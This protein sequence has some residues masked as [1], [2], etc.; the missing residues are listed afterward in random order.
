[1]T[2]GAIPRMRPPAGSAMVGALAMSAPATT[3]P[4][5]RGRRI[6]GRRL[7]LYILAL[8]V[9]IV[10]PTIVLPTLVWRRPAP[11]LD[12]LGALPAFAL[13]AHTGEPFTDAEMRGHVSV[14]DFIFTRCDAI[15]PVLS[16]KMQGLQKATAKVGDRIKLVSFSVDP[17]HDTPAVLAAYAE[18]FQADPTRWAF[19]TGDST[20]VRRTIE[21]GLMV[22][23][24]KLGTTPSGA[25]NI[26]HSGHMVLVDR[27]GHVR[28]LYDSNDPQRLQDLQHHARWLSRQP[29]RQPPSP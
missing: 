17:E 12:D 4:V 6:G 5:P 16:M 25:P 19:V 13:T 29:S 10:T 9:A 1:M 3:D 7:F 2:Q 11:H 24:D 27:D 20:V 21:Q 28:G 14:V 26:N 23:Y 8:L 18:R 22:G 15:C